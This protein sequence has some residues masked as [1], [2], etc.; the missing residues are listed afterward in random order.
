[1]YLQL[2]TS[3]SKLV[4]AIWF[5]DSA[6]VQTL[7]SEGVDIAGTN[8]RQTLEKR[9]AERFFANCADKIIGEAAPLIEIEFPRLKQDQKAKVID[10]L[11]KGFK[12][13]TRTKDL[14]SSGYSHEVLAK[15]II[16]NME[17]YESFEI[18]EKDMA[19]L[20][21]KHIAFYI[22]QF[23]HAAPDFVPSSL[24]QLLQGQEEILQILSSTLKTSLKLIEKQSERSLDDIR[25]SD[26]IQSL[27]SQ[28]QIFGL[29]TYSIRRK[30]P[31]ETAY[32]SLNV[33]DE[34]FE[35]EEEFNSIPDYH[36]HTNIGSRIEDFIS[37]GD[38]FVIF[39]SPGSGKTTLLQ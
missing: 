33:S 34:D 22:C 13:S 20:L 10:G 35:Y 12:K 30:Y 8:L 38:H 24:N 14:V 4:G 27:Y 16:E 9:S 36:S 21:T 3:V 37:Y 26:R 32:I 15:H 39:G 1:M 25:Y 11:T 19:N 18:A 5:G 7:F 2:A 23:K 28:V 29:S 6:V 31:L 17:D